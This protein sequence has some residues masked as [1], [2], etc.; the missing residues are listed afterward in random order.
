MKITRSLRELAWGLRESI[1]RR[2]AWA[3]PPS[4]VMWAALRVVAHATAGRH[5]SQNVSELH[6]MTAVARWNDD[7]E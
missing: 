7:H 6:A 2:V 3:L 1:P 4:V 5:E